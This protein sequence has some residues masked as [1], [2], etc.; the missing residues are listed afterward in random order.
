MIAAQAVK[1]T[2]TIVDQADLQRGRHYLWDKELRG[3]GVCIETSGTKTYFVRYRPK[4]HG[5]DGKRRFYKLGRHGDIT[6][7]EA[8]KLA[9]AALGQVAS[10]NDPAAEREAERRGVVARREAPTFKEIA[11]LFMQEHLD[12]KRKSSTAATYKIMFRL[13]V[14]PKLGSLKADEVTRATL[15]KMH[16][17][18]S[19]KP[20]N[21]NRL[22]AVISSLYSFAAKRALVPE[23]MNPAKGIERYREEGRERYL[24]QGELQRL[25]S[26]LI[27]AET[28]G[29][30]WDIDWDGP[31][32]KHLPKSAA[33]ERQVIDAHA[34][35]AIRLLLFTGARLREILH[36]RGEYVDMDRRLL[37]LPDSKTG[38]KTIVLSGEALEIL[39]HLASLVVASRQRPTK[40]FEA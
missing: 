32:A 9:K 26:T 27:E 1:I 12:A 5:R 2:K 18:M 15:S 40:N 37:L 36:L 14:Y 17:S 23:G 22:L 31:K 7:D 30:P 6:P 28:V 25:G 29:L 3:F 35:A 24:T 11:E 38:K 10:G 39:C 33:E 13:H 19:D 8:R 16:A 34:V 21:A 4:G 20:Y